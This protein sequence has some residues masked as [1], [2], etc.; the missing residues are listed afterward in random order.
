MVD[1]DKL[2]EYDDYVEQRVPSWFSR[3]SFQ[4]PVLSNVVCLTVGFVIGALIF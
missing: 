2:D 4:Y 1:Q 3:M